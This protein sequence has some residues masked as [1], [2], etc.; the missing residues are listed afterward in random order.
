GGYV[1][2]AKRAIGEH[3]K[4]PAGYTLLWTGQYGFQVRPGDRFKVLIP[5][6]FF[7]I[8]VLLYL[9]FHSVSEAT[10]VMLSVVY[11]MTGGVVRQW[12][13]GSNFPAAGGWEI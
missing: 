4:L 11:A 2:R 12:M 8:F 3:V 9:T 5:L 6:V 13:P 10:I 1:D 7:L